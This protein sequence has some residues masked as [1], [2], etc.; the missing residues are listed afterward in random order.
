MTVICTLAAGGYHRYPFHSICSLADGL[1]RWVS[2]VALGRPAGW[3]GGGGFLKNKKPKC[4]K[5]PRTGHFSH[6]DVLFFI[7][8]TA[9]PRLIGLAAGGSKRYLNDPPA[10]ATALGKW[11]GEINGV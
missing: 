5:W 2:R 6:F 1:G 4:Q 3:V 10:K 11:V 9:H 7:S 8:S